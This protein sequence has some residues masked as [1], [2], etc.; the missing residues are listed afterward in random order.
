M[1]NNNIMKKLIFIFIICFSSQ[2][3]F[4]DDVTAFVENADFGINN[5]AIT[6]TLSAGIAPYTFTW[7]GPAGFISTEQNIT[8]LVA[9]EYCV[10]VTD[11][12]CGVATLCVTVEEGVQNSLET[13]SASTVA[14]FP[15][16]FDAGFTISFLLSAP[17]DLNF[18]LMDMNGK[19]IDSKQKTL[20]AGENHISFD[21]INP[22]ASGDYLLTIKDNQFNTFTHQI[23][24]LK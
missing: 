15:N 11:N 17:G 1:T 10:T 24:H 9:G 14:I 18:T 13:F 19:T 22:I 2:H 16:P 12:L 5:G 21:V 23:L 8:D 6:L 20:P 4:A 3:V 7:T